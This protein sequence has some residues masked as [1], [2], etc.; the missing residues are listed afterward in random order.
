MLFSI[1]PRRIAGRIVILHKYDYMIPLNSFKG[2]RISKNN[3]KKVRLFWLGNLIAEA[4]K[5]GYLTD[6][7]PLVNI[8]AANFLHT[9]Q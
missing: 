8:T 9:G 2:N 1:I 3:S 4:N 5:S 6:K 7:G